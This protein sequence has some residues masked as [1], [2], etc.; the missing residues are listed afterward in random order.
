VVAAQRKYPGALGE[1]IIPELDSDGLPVVGSVVEEGD[2][3]YCAVDAVTGEVEVG[4]H[5]ESERAYVETVRVLGDD[6]TGKGDGKI[7]KV[8]YHHRHFPSSPSYIY[9]VV[10]EVVEEGLW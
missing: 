8:G 3:L 5:K 9:S 2:P 4:K 6:T 1:A 10:V 7:D